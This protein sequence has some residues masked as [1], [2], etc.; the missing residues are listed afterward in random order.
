MAKMILAEKSATATNA[1][2]TLLTVKTAGFRVLSLAMSV[3]DYALAELE[4]IGRV[5]INA[6]WIDIATASAAFAVETINYPMLSTTG[7]LTTQAIGDGAFILDCS[8]YR[9]IA[10][11]A[12]SSNVAGSDIN[13]YYS[14]CE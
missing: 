14:I 1:L 11:K 9:D 3:A 10:I 4:I 5:G 13:F 12:K 6:P 7:D 8:G 2:T